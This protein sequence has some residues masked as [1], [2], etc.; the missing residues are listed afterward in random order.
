MT[1]F[2]EWKARGVDLWEEQGKEH[3]RAL[4]FFAQIK[5]GDTVKIERYAFPEY[6]PYMSNRLAHIHDKK[7]VTV[8]A[9]NQNGLWF[10][11][12][13]GEAIGADTLIK[14]EKLPK[15]GELF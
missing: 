15:Q 3:R 11:T 12:T 14:W 13:A 4:D 10:T 1:E 8:Y 2:E 6:H 5:P 7:T 9:M